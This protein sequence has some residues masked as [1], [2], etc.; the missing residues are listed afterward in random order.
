MTKKE[1]IAKI[2][3]M[4][5]WIKN[6]VPADAKDPS[7]KADDFYVGAVDM[8]PGKVLEVVNGN[9]VKTNLSDAAVKVSD[10]GYYEMNGKEE[11]EHNI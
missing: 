10:G 4:E 1:Q 7:S 3:E 5:E 6:G 9:E 8:K 2:K 11:N